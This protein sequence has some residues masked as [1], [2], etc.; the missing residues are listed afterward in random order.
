MKLSIESKIVLYNNSLDKAKL[1][2]LE[3][4]VLMSFGQS[5]QIRV[6]V[7]NEPTDLFYRGSKILEQEI[8]DLRKLLIK[9]E[10]D[11]F[12][13]DNILEKS[14]TPDDQISKF[15]YFVGG[16]ML[17]LFLSFGIIFSKDILKV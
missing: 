6:Q 17:G 3:N 16:A 4:P 1:A 2:N 14:L 10:N 8:T 5:N 12:N 11:Q 13:F 7:V 15:L 9:L